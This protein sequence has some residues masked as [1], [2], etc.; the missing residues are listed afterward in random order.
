MADK[1]SRQSAGSTAGR[2]TRP[3][4]RDELLEAALRLF[5]AHGVKNT[6]IRDITG[7]VG[8][9]EAAL[10][11]H[12]PSKQALAEELIEQAS[13][14]LTERLR[15]AEEN[16]PTPET[17]L[18][19]LIDELFTYYEQDRDRFDL[20]VHVA[21]LDPSMVENRSSRPSTVVLPVL[22]EGIRTRVFRK[23]KPELAL[24]LIIGAVARTT[25]LRRMGVIKGSAA[26]SRRTI[27]EMA[28]RALRA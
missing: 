10:Y 22:R 19:A 11:R 16:A 20:V 24:A 13:A 15:E 14:E 9:T 27:R 5:A 3:S 18:A 4:H 21:H 1:K 7:A 17:K 23:T 26:N 8:V 25:Q 6:T 12:W 2:R 28:L